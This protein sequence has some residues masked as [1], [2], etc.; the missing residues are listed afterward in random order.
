MAQDTCVEAIDLGGTDTKVGIVASDGRVLAD[1]V[2]ATDHERGGTAWAEQTARVIEDLSDR[3]QVC[4]DR[5]GG[6]GIGAP[7]PLSVREGILTNPMPN[8]PGWQG[9][10]ICAVLSEL[11]GKPSR[12]DND[13]NCAALAEHWIGAGKGIADLI[14][15][16]LGTGIGS[17]VIVEDRLLHGFSDNAGELGH[18]SINYR[19]PR[20]VCGNRGCIELYASAPAVVRL[21]RRKVASS[22]TVRSRRPKLTARDVFEAAVGGDARAR[23]TFEQVGR[24]LGMAIANMVHAFNPRMVVLAGGLAEAAEFMLEAI[25]QTVSEHTYPEHQA[26]LEIRASDLGRRAGLLGAARLM[27]DHC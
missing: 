3:A 5:I 8:L 22:K 7:G 25:E 4:R 20:C 14:V 11:R 17:G 19:G 16:T 23:E 27:L 24:F 9:F 26:G 13:A 1:H 21:Y 12:L 10:P 2:F 15:L 6:I 18:T